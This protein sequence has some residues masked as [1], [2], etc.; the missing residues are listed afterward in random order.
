LTRWLR[1]PSAP[2]APMTVLIADFNNHTGDPV[3]SGTLESSL[4]LALEGA[5]FINAY[6]R[7]RMRDLGL[8]AISG[9]LD[10]SKAQEIA[11]NH[12]LKV[13]ISGDAQW[14]KHRQRRR[15]RRQ[16]RSGLVRSDEAWHRCT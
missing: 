15:D 8:K 13:L 6:D 11:T 4:K 12:G 14:Q 1:R 5:S 7:T 2:V 3:F 16:Q 9:T 10:D